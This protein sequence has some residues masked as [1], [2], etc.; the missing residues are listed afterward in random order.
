MEKGTVNGESR[1]EYVDIPEND[2]IKKDV[3]LLKSM[4]VDKSPEPN[5]TYPRIL[6]D[7]RKVID[8]GRGVDVGYMGFSEAFDKILH[9]RLMYKMKS[10]DI[11]SELVICIHN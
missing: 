2:Y 8:E 10:H 5:E 1:V 4:K 7:V 11:H 3:Y 6:R 9:G